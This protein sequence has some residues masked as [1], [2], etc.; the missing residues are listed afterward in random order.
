MFVWCLMFFERENMFMTNTGAV[1]MATRIEVTKKLK[2]GYKTASKTEKGKSSIGSAR[3][4]ACLGPQ[5][6]GI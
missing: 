1:S 5:H 3:S 2:Q 4:L 6:G